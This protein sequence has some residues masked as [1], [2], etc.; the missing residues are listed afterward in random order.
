MAKK[1]GGIKFSRLLHLVVSYKLVC[2]TSYMHAHARR[3]SAARV[4]TSL[5]WMRWRRSWQMAAAYED[6][7]STRA[8]ECQG[9]EK[10]LCERGGPA[11]APLDKNTQTL[12]LSGLLSTVYAYLVIDD[13][14]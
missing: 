9:W 3:M 12:P 14:D 2:M 1:S 10:C 5:V 8:H 7:T 11:W 4:R 13:V 6:M